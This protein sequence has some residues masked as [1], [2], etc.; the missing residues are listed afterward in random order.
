MILALAGS[1]KKYKNCC[2]NKVINVDFRHE[3]Y[4]DCVEEDDAKM[5]FALKNLLFDYINQKYHINK[6]LEDFSDICNAEPE[7]VREI[8]E[9]L[10]N[11]ENII[12]N[13]IKENPNELDEEFMR[14]I[15]EWNKKKVNKEFILYKYE[16]EYAIFMDDENV[17]YVKGLKERIRDMIPENKLPMFVK[18]VLLPLNGQIVYDSYIQQYNISFGKGMRDIWDKNYHKLL[19]EKKIKYTL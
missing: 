2:I 9:K 13:Y 17:Y 18:T 7:E 16:E 8:R 4:N 3:K 15:E 1:G 6:D 19:I 14:T 11:D 12:K 10:W 5:F